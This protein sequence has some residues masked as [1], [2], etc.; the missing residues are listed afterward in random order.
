MK[1]SSKYFPLLTFFQ[2]VEQKEIK[3]HFDRIEDVL[4]SKLPQSARNHRGW[5]SN[6]SRGA[7]QAGAWLDAGFEVTAVSIKAQTATFTKI[8]H[9]YQIN[10]IGDTIMWNGGLVKGL[11]RYMQLTQQEL[12]EELGVRQQTISEWETNIY[13]PSRAMS[14]YLALV[15]E[16]VGF[17]Y[18]G[19]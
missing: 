14:K 16:K 13:A 4:G 11:R 3:V 12:A 5:W 1:Q 18:D 6:R 7:V 9:S 10:R 15:S 17:G 19:T 2:A 8:A